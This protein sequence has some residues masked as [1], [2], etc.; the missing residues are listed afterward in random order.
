MAS[1]ASKWDNNRQQTLLHFRIS[2][3]HFRNTKQYILYFLYH[4]GCWNTCAYI[5]LRKG[6]RILHIFKGVMSIKVK[7]SL[8]Q[9]PK[10][11]KGRKECDQRSGSIVQKRDKDA[12][13]K[14]T[15]AGQVSHLLVGASLEQTSHIVLVSEFGKCQDLAHAWA[16][17]AWHCVLRRDWPGRLV[18]D[19]DSWDLPRWCR[20]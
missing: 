15:L 1:H 8:N 3:I 7:E 5:F 12:R 18:W 2:S 19:E 20:L 4:E 14:R 6:Y 10:N 16:D 13:T 17:E 9:W 11:K